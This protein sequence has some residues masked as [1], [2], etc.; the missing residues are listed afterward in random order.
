[1]RW[2]DY[3]ECTELPAAI[4]TITTLTLM[5]VVS[6][7]TAGTSSAQQLDKRG[8]LQAFEPTGGILGNSVSNLFLNGDSLWAGPFISVTAD[9]GTTWE[10]PSV[11][12]LLGESRVFSLDIE[13]QTVVIGLGYNDEDNGGIQTAGGFLV[14]TDG[15][16][17]FTLRQ[18]QI[19]SPGDTLV[20]YG[21][22]TIRALDIIVPQ[23]SPPYDVD[24]D[25][26]RGE[27][28]VAGWA[29][30]IRKSSDEGRSWERVVLPPD[31]LDAIQPD[32]AYD[33][34]IEPRRGNLGNFNHMGFSVLLASDGSIWAGTPKGVN[35][36]TDG[37]SWRRIEPDGTSA[38]M[39]GSWVVAM[40]E[41][42]TQSGSAIWMATW[43]ALET[44]DAGGRSGVSVTRDGGD[45]FEQVLTGERFIDFAFSGE[46]AWVAGRTSGLFFSDDNGATWTTIRDFTL[47][48]PD[49]RPVK[50][51]TDVLAVAADDDEVWVGTSDGILR[52]VDGGLTWSS[53]RVEVP[54][55]PAVETDEIPSVDTFA[56]PN[57]FSPVADRFVRIRYETQSASD[58]EVTIFDFGMNVVRQLPAENRSTGISES[59]WDGTDGRGL[60]MANGTYFYSVDTGSGVVWGKILLLE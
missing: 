59:V 51:G 37:E 42:V 25:A 60:R 5:L 41:Q 50:F 39:T 49:D 7:G 38:S 32:I 10:T 53:F 19:D 13:R 16:E 30:G 29:S 48:S 36:S 14:S 12:T 28:W 17:N 27:I 26:A 22:S 20:T 3:K 47:A 46:R 57:P 44:G 43:E 31:T 55:K 9:G 2:T 45:T 34:V 35:V 6:I 40:A 1:M 11:E 58:V 56:Y 15:G 33:F 23:Q 24:Y 21:V 18:P 52:S 54:L 4:T 8:A